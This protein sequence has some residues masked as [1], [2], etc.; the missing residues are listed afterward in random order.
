MWRTHCAPSPHIKPRTSGPP[1]PLVTR[2]T[3]R[4]RQ[5]V[6]RVLVA[7][8]NPINQAVA[9]RLLEK[10]GHT[11]VMTADGGD[12]VRRAGEESFD[13]IMMDLQMPGVDGIEATRR[14]RR[15][16]QTTGRHIPII[17]LTAHAMEGD[18]DRCLAAGMD[19]YLT[20]P[21]QPDD[22]FRLIDALGNPEPLAGGEARLASLPEPQGNILDR[23]Q[24]KMPNR[25]PRPVGL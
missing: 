8:D 10:R 6:L 14:I 25:L 16:E 18:R 21:L 12:A 23:E 17:A 20:K 9:C 22:L 2:H 13:L 4:E 24:L 15:S 19:A 1:P 3:L 5:R 7:E 11:V